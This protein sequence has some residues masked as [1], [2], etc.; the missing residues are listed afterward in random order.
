MKYSKKENTKKQTI[1]TL[2]LLINQLSPG[3][4]KGGHRRKLSLP[5]ITMGR[6]EA[7]PHFYFEEGEFVATSVPFDPWG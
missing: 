4:K 5:Q 3:V 1:R 6:R 2:M 7:P